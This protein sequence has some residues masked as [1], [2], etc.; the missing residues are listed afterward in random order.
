MSLYTSFA[1]DASGHL[2]AWGINDG[3]RVAPPPAGARDAARPDGLKRRS[4]APG[5]PAPRACGGPSCRRK[6][7]LV[8]TPG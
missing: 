4:Y 2:L 3:S 1:I 5:T 6:K 7:K 8:D